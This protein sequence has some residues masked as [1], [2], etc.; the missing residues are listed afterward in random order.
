[1]TCFTEQRLP[2]CAAIE[3]VEHDE[4][5]NNFL[6]LFGE[7]VT[8]PPSDRERNLSRDWHTSWTRRF[9]PR[10]HASTVA[11]VS[12]VPAI[13]LLRPS[14]ENYDIPVANRAMQVSATW[15]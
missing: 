14:L 4:T 10:K 8:F 13:T 11:F 5:T 1:M 2:P 7:Q 12:I 15:G 9:L 6:R 3:S